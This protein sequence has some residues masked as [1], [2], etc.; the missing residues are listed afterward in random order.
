MKL[1]LKTL[2]LGVIILVILVNAAYL[3]LILKGN[4]I[5]TKQLEALTHRKV[6]LGYFNVIFP[7]KLEIYNLNIEGLLKAEKVFISP[8]ILYLLTGNIALNNVRIIRPQITYE[9][10][11]PEMSGLS[12]QA[13][14][15]ETDIAAKPSVRAK[16]NRGSTF[17]LRRLSI[18]D[19]KID[20]A[21]RL[22][23][24]EGISITA[25]D[26]AFSL[27]NIYTFTHAVVTNFELKGRIPWQEGKEEGKIEAEGWFNSFKKDMQATLKI[28]DIDAIYLYPY[29]AN[30]LDLEKARIES[31]NLNF[32][33]S[34]NGL[35]NNVIAD[36]HLEL[37]DIVRK[38]RP[39]SQPPEK[40]ER[41]ADAILGA[42]KDSEE[43][44]I[45]LDF[46]V[47]TKMDRPEFSFSAI[48]EAVEHKL[49][50]AK[51]SEGFQPKNILMLPAQLIEGTVKGATDISKA[52]IDGTFAVGNELKNAV[53]DS[54]RREPQE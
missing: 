44:M 45:A 48:K 34:I 13:A 39:P 17:I 12:I 31:A 40:A 33:S 36:C 28:K 25:K 20:F 52:V 11:S 15:A 5:I 41:I 14:S 46:T 54:F 23:S 24:S 1:W 50:K 29:Y 2:F 47:K 32:T 22:V 26:I 53:Q 30:W 21:D 6:S 8:S 4:A 18:K 43:K 38:P 27:T 7:L 51:T 10:I 35:N 49:A 37:T 3:F 42:F 19:G 9:R 16:K